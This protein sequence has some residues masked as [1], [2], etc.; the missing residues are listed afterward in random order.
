MDKPLRIVFM[1]T[2]EF[3]VPSLQALLR[4]DPETVGRVVGVVTQPDR[5]K[6]RGQQLAPPPIKV[7]AQ[8]A[9]LPILQP[10]K[11]KD[12][13]FLDALRSWI[14][15]VIAVTAFGRILPPAILD[16]PPMGCINVHGSLLPKYR[17]A[18]P[19]QWAVINGETE[20]GI[21]TML[22]DPG[23]DTGPM[24]LREPVPINSADT[25]GDLAARLAP[26][27]GRL[28]VETIVGLKRGTLRPTPQDHAKATLAPLLKKEDGMLDWKDGAAALS[29]R[30]RG[31]T[32]W[33][34]AY[35]YHG[36]ERWQLWRAQTAPVGCAEAAPGTI[37]EITK[38]ALRVATGKG[39]LLLQ[40]IQPAS[41]KR[42]NVSQYLAGH[43]VA[44]GA[45]LAPSPLAAP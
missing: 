17:G 26:L 45:R 9:G 25:A 11:M 20:T 14:P 32:P 4:A 43:R 7:L 27:G 15:D 10:A 41:G 34:G 2:P 38:D 16:L 29:N 8:Q 36:E 35:T 39:S 1:G 24:L 42:L 3:A 13:D 44:V 5:P 21:T 6:G 19:I 23:L 12:P 40:E 37:L 30:I 28:L 33:P 31:L 18:A 22:M